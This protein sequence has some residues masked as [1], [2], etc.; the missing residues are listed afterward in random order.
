M[1]IVPYRSS[2]TLYVADSI[3]ERG[4]SVINS[5][6]VAGYNA[7][8]RVNQES[9]FEEIVKNPPHIIIFNYKDEHFLKSEKQYEEMFEK[10][11]SLLPEVHII[12]LTEKQYSEE[13]AQLYELGIYDCVTWPTS[14]PMNMLRAVDRAVECDYYMYLNEQLHETSDNNH[15]GN[16]FAL[17]EIWLKELEKCKAK[18]ELLDLW[19]KEAKRVLRTDYGLFLQ[20]IESKKTL[21]VSQYCGQPPQDIMGMGIDLVADEPGFEVSMLKNPQEMQSLQAFV[22]KGLLRS[23]AAFFTVI[24]RDQVLGVFIMP[25]QLQQ[26][27]S[28]DELDSSYLKSC[29]RMVSRQLE[30]FELRSRLDKYSVYDAESDAFRTEFILKKI[31]EEISRARR[32]L[33]PFSLILLSIDGYEDMILNMTREQHDKFL[34]SFA[35]ILISNSRLNDLVGRV[36]RDQFVVCLPHTEL[37][38]GA[39]KAERFRRIIENAD[40][41]SI[42]KGIKKITVSLGVS[43]YPSI[44]HDGEQL[45][46]SA[47]Q[48]MLGVKKTGNNRT[49]VATASE[50]FTPDFL[51][52][53]EKDV[54]SHSG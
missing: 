38:G 43:E 19:L 36:D 7:E 47:E 3:I 29:M 46:N 2:F 49:A 12:I 44:C 16:N 23:Q 34:K 41:S 42:M 31:K 32:I 11:H 24:E 5:L 20:Y 54:S 25:A 13:A 15:V 1:N 53:D 21:V 9:L 28:K 48:A 50:R 17:F 45:L 8:L 35:E 4:T 37:K 40:F 26:N 51:V 52:K 30:L 10:I 33:K 6:N 22:V 18:D 27:F 39:V 14:A